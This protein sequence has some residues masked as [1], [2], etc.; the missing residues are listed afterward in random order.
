MKEEEEEE[1]EE[2]ERTTTQSH[3]S[4]V[5]DQYSQ[6]SDVDKIECRDSACWRCV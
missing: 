1:E 5:R 4:R 2:E 3:K 6:K